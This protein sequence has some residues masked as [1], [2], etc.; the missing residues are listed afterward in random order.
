M[1][2]KSLASL[3]VSVYAG[4]QVVLAH[5]A[6]PAS[7]WSQVMYSWAGRLHVWILFLSSEGIKHSLC[8]VLVIY[9]TYLLAVPECGSIPVLPSSKAIS[10][11]LLLP[12]NFFILNQQLVVFIEHIFVPFFFFTTFLF[13]S[14]S[15]LDMVL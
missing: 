13:E 4:H 10:R 11:P 8:T 9:R 3:D 1:L 2:F 15:V 12:L 7:T 14:L 5:R 6:M